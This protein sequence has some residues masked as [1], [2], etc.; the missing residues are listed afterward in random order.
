MSEEPLS[1]GSLWAATAQ[2]TR[3]APLRGDLRSDVCVIGAGISGLTTAYLLA[4]QGVKTVAILRFPQAGAVVYRWSGEV[5]EPLDGLAYL[6]RNPGSERVYVITGDSGNAIAHGTIGGMLVT[7]LVMGRP[8]RWSAIY[9][10][11]HKAFREALHF[12]EQH[13]T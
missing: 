9:D 11:S 5:M 10:P 6:G 13:R 7:D 1:C 12:L 2:V 3:C 8:N 4:R